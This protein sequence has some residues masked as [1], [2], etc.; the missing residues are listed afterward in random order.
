LAPR[1]PDA[2]PAQDLG[3]DSQV[4]NDP[5]SMCEYFYEP[6]ARTLMFQS[7]P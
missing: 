1:E 4:G 5:S 2:T 6:S 7:Q 3:H